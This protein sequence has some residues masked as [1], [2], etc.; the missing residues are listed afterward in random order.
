MITYES[1]DCSKGV[2]LN[3]SGVKCMICCYYYFK[4]IGFKYQPYVRNGCHD[5]SIGVKNLSDFLF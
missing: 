1:I 2:D 4:D 3:K 5:F